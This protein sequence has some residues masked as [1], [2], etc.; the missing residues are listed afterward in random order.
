MFWC[1]TLPSKSHSATDTTERFQSKAKRIKL[2]FRGNEANTPRRNE[3]EQQQYVNL[4]FVMAHRYK[5][6]RD[7]V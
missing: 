7:T 6:D 4:C 2:V 5:I 3:R 1:H